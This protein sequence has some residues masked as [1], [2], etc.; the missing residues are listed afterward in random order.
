MSKIKCV[1][2]VA[3]V[4]GLISS[5]IAV[6]DPLAAGKPA[7]VKQAQIESWPPM[8]W[9]ALAGVAAAGIAAAASSGNSPSTFTTVPATTGTTA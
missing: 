9:V 7:G 1:I 8:V 6:A 2:S 4:I 5:S 3:T